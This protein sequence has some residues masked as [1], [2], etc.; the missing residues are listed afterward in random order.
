MPLTKGKSKKVIAKN[1]R[2]M[3][4]SGHPQRV[5]VAAALHTAEVPKKGAK[6]RA[7]R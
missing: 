1:I 3:V 6:K 2:E 4:H 5:A 7:K